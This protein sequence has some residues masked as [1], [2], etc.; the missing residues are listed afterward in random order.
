M[1]LSFLTLS[2]ATSTTLFARSSAALDLDV[3]DQQSIKSVAKTLAGG[4]V[5]TYK[6]DLGES[7]IPGLFSDPYYWWEAG[8]VFGSLVDYSFLTGDNQYDDLVGEAL[9]HQI[10]DFN[11]FLPVNQT[12]TLGNDDQSTWGLAA[13]S[14]AENGFTTSKIG[15]LS[16]IDL[17]KNVF[18]SQARRWDSK[19]CDGGLRWQIY[20]FNYGYSYKNS[21]SSGQFFLLAA[22]LA[23]FTGN[24]TYSDWAEKAF[25][26][27]QD[28]G[29]ID[30]YHV[31]DGADADEGCSDVN[32]IQWPSNHAIFT[33]AAAYMYNV[34]KGSDKW[35]TVVAGFL[36]TSSVF[37]EDGGILFNVACENNGKCNT[38][39]R[40]MKGLAARSYA[41]AAIFAPFIAEELTSVLE[42]SAKGAAEGCSG[43]EA[44]LQCSNKWTGNG[45]PSSG[46]GEVFGALAVVQGL[47]VKDA[48]APATASDRGTGTSA[49]SP[50]ANA[51]AASGSD[52]PPENE[53]AA[54][55]LTVSRGLSL[56]VAALVVV[57][58]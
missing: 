31:Y 11:A 41:R 47:L 37:Q 22:R 32:R 43:K 39:Q 4:I 26:W 8:A 50:T 24:E 16:W 14:A 45:E 1:F 53:G 54:G 38:D 9:E 29:L 58:L 55:A 51:P 25:E 20:E 30:D 34:T 15:N 49:G 46:L 35:K 19:T 5:A 13:M 27:T 33:E 21:I 28:V 6:N 18:D 7:L 42:A 12:K 56:A 3:K 40:A 44:K 36:N 2:L 52:Q 57:L 17:A 23:K 48:K 10:G